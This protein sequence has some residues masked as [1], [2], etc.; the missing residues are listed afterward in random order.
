MEEKRKRGRPRKQLPEEL[1]RVVDIALESKEKEQEE[2]HQVTQE[3][4]KKYR[5]ESEWDIKT[6]E[7]IEFFDSRLSYEITGYKPIDKTHGLDF[8]PA[9]YTEA[10]ETFKKTGKYCS[11]APGTKLYRDFW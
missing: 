7:S 11:Y 8:D 2:I 3:V 5:G 4:K 6:D 1:Q 10:A 9:W